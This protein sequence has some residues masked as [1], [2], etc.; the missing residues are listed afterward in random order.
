MLA[1][2]ATRLHPVRPVHQGTHPG[3]AAGP[4]ATTRIFKLHDRLV[5]GQRIDAVSLANELELDKRT[6]K[7]DLDLLKNHGAPIIWDA[8]LKSYR[9]TAPFDLASGLRLTA[10]EAH[11]LVLAGHTLTAWG[12]AP[13][14]P[15][16][17]ATLEKV[18]RFAGPAIS[19]PA[20][21]LHA[22]LHQDDTALDAPEHRHFSRLLEDVRARRE[23]IVHYQKP[24]ASRAERR[25]LRPL[26]LAYL[27]HRWMLVAEDLG[28]KAW[29][30]FLLPRIHAIEPTVRTFDPPPTTRVKTYLAGSLGRFT[31]D[32]EIEVRLRFSATAAPYLRERPW[33][34]SQTTKS[35]PHGAVEA[36]LRLNN[37]IDVQRRILASGHHIEVLAPPELRTALAIEIAHLARTYAQEIR[38]L[39]KTA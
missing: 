3:L 23:I 9:Y 12:A 27:D 22:V 17:T 21:E 11:S 32:R 30:N 8:K 10:E 16:L 20:S 29:R 37:L 2:M 26:H 18:A 15:T 25:A 39:E 38:A 5:A 31:G 28:K 33:H 7:R 13:L 35:L 4:S 1:L 19:F 34:A 6:I 14:G 36:T 24:T